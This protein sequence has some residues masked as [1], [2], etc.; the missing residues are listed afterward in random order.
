MEDSYIGK[1]AFAN[2]KLTE[3]T[4]PPNCKYESDAFPE[5]CVVNGGIKID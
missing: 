5:N 1:K 3:V 4:L 2:T